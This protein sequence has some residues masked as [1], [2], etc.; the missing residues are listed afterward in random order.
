MTRMIGYAAVALL[1]ACAGAPRSQAKGGPRGLRASEHLDAAREHDD[2]ARHPAGFP[3]PQVAPDATAL[4]WL[5]SWDTST[6]QDRL[7]DIHR[8][9]AARL[10]AE[11]EEACGSRSLE[12]IAISPLQRHATSGWRTSAGMILYL[13]PSAGS[14]DKL[15]ADMKCHRAWMMLAPTRMD[16]CPLD[17]PGIVI[18]AHGDRDNI[19]VS[20]AVRD[21]K[22]VGELQRRAEHD[23]ES[24]AQLRRREH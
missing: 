22:L 9:E 17:V 15:L 14:P 12:E 21:P 18:D 6:E 20:I 2:I 8:S 4:P 5:R 19:T 1:V 3:G 24:G 7:A 10:Q 11:F 13:D 16:D 23:L